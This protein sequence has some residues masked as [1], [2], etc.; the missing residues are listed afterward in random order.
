M[1]GVVAYPPPAHTSHSTP[2]SG[3]SVDSLNGDIERAIVTSKA[4]FAQNPQDQSIQTRLKALL[5]LQ[6]ILRAQSLP[7]EQLVLVKNQIAELAVNARMGPPAQTSTPIPQTP[8]VAVAP[9]PPAVQTA[10][11]VPK[12]SLDSL[13]GPGALAAIMAR[14]S[15]TPQSSTPQPPPQ[16]AAIRSPPPQRAEPQKSATPMPS[17]PGALLAMLR[18][19]GLLS[20]A[21]TPSGGTPNPPPNPTSSLPFP[22]PLPGMAPPIA[23]PIPGA[24]QSI[25]QICNGI[26]LKA[27]SLKQYVLSG[28]LYPSQ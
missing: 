28:S 19:S 15:A 8:A 6:S 13:L 1:S 21:P 20:T 9:P 2:Q 22:F 23:L 11:T 27:S 4:Q 25:E 16:V 10:G 24:F 3:I 18:K 26:D 17:D 14:Q 5:D 7:Q 12:V